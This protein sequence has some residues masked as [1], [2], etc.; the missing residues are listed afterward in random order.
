MTDQGTKFCN[1]PFQAYLDDQ[2]IHHQMS[3]VYTPAQNGFIERDNRVI[4][5]SARSMIYAKALPKTLWVEA[6]AT[7][8]HILNRTSN[9]Q[10]GNSTPYECWFHRKPSVQHF[11]IFGFAA[12]VF[13]NTKLRTKLDSKSI[14]AYFVGYSL[15]SKA[16]RF[17]SPSTDQIF[18]SFDYRIDE[19]SGPYSP[20]LSFPDLSNTHVEHTVDFSTSVSSP[21]PFSHISSSTTDSIPIPSHTEN[22]LPSPIT[23]D[24]FQDDFSS[25]SS[26]ADFPA[27]N[28][29]S[30]S[31]LSPPI[32]QPSVGD[33][34]LP[35][36]TSLSPQLILP[37]GVES[38][39]VDDFSQ[40]VGDLSTSMENSVPF[41]SPDSLN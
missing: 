14:F 13:V 34:V 27:A 10:L 28:I 3:T 24:N 23:N 7:A 6:V 5:E 39:S 31:N 16:Y 11:R 21:L 35:V 1:A 40:S 8:I 25:Y 4:M 26:P 33:L 38:S 18:E 36:R 17:W 15:T 19:F 2:G 20:T 12:Y 29:P 30:I 32:L 22:L 9:H 37:V 41:S